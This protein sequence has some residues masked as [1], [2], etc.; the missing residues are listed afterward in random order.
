MGGFVGATV[1]GAALRADLWFPPGDA[2][3][4]PAVVGVHGLEGQRS[5]TPEWDLE[6]ARAG[7]VVI[8]VD[9]RVF[10]VA[11]WQEQTADIACALG[12]AGANAARLGVDPDRIAL[13]GSSRAGR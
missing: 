1:G 6:L 9:Y 13:V 3:D 12:W 5:E 11:R 10:P 2:R 8:D 4:R 7:A